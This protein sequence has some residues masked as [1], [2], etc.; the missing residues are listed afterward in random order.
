MT[1]PDRMTDMMLTLSEIRGD[2]RLIL[3]RMD[4]HDKRADGHEAKLDALDKRMDTLEAST[5]T[6]AQLEEKSKRTVAIVSV[7]MTVMSLLVGT[8]VSI[9]AI[10]VR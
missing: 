5:V 2:V 4:Q 1:V 10:I 7:V 8:G 6:R 9:I 3:Q